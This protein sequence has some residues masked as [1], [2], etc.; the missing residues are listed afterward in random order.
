MKN[1]VDYEI[2][3]HGVEHEQYFQGCG[4]TFTKFD[5]VFTGIGDSE[6]EAL[7]DALNIASLSGWNTDTI[8]N[9]KS[10]ETFYDEYTGDDANEFNDIH[11]YVSIRL[12]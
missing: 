7:E 11:H 4:A 9:N 6:H 8:D 2:I 12:R 5:A 3:N 10:K 1:I